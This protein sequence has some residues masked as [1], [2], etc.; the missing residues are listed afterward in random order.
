MN[1][2]RTLSIGTLVLIAA[3]CVDPY[4]ESPRRDRSGPKE[5][6]SQQIGF[7]EVRTRIFEPHCVRCHAHY[8][9]YDGVTRDLAGIST[10]IASGR[11][12]KGAGRLDEESRSLLTAWIEG[13]A[14]KDAKDPAPPKP[15]V[16]NLEPRWESLAASVF[17]PKCMS[18]HNPNGQARFLDLTSRFAIFAARDKRVG[19]MKLIDFDSPAE[20]AL[21]IVLRDE[22][23]PMPPA[24][25]GMPR[26]SNVEI[27]TI[28]TWIATGMP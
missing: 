8:E 12:P 18:C 13:G 23:E 24:E 4:S 19:A 1:L 21:L 5:K 22:E 26:L 20:S 7:D 16:Q 17:A 11:M 25:S 28:E 6:E 10:A 14:Q 15:P 9:S 2:L 3:G 27:G